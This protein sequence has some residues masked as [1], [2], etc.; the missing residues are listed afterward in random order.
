MVQDL[1]R[2]VQAFKNKA[3]HCKFEFPYIVKGPLLEPLST[4]HDLGAL[5]KA[6]FCKKTLFF[7]V[8]K[9][10]GPSHNF[11]HDMKV[12]VTCQACALISHYHRNSP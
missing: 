3:L 11:K 8:I 12:S 10:E 4:S 7:N 1:L 9:R 6:K 2:K 5:K